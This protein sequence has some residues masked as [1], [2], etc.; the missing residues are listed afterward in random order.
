MSSSPRNVRV[1]RTTRETAITIALSLDGA[2][3][4]SVRTGIGFFDHMLTAFARHG[5]FDLTV[6]A[7]G[8]LP[9][10]THHTVEDV[11]IVLGQAFREALGDL[12]GLER[13]GSATVP[14]DDALALAA[15]DLCGRPWLALEFPL[16]VE[17]IGSFETETLPSFLGALANGAGMNLHLRLLAGDNAHHAVEAGFKALA[18][19]LDQAT[20]RDPRVVGVPSTKGVLQA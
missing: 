13:F 18:R 3:A 8:D 17:R 1:T 12:A 19:A 20:R 5:L 4:A 2:G 7:V 11:G 16:P 9:V 14:M 15:V 10:D 6:D